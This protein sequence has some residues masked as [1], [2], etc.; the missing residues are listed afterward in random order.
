[1][2][3]PISMTLLKSNIGAAVD[4]NKVDGVGNDNHP[5][6]LNHTSSQNHTRFNSEKDEIHL[7]STRTVMVVHPD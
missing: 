7:D 3:N 6:T 5:S 2:A 4:Y 1:M